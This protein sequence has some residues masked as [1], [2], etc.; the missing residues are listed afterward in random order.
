MSSRVSPTVP[1]VLLALYGA[2]LAFVLLWP[3]G[4]VASGGVDVLTAGVRALGVDPRLASP[5]LVEI[6]ANVAIMVPPAALARVVWPGPRWWRWA[7]GGFTVAVTAEVAQAL[8]L[9]ERFPSPVDV[10]ANTL[11]VAIGA[12]LVRRRGDRGGRGG[13]RRGDPGIR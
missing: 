7:L 5:A 3:G 13:P 6:L 11:G 8:F 1:R 4:G 10:V 9:P 12:A 2:F